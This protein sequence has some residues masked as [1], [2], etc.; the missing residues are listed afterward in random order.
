MNC[1]EGLDAGKKISFDIKH[2]GFQM[3]RLTVESDVCS[4]TFYYQYC[5]PFTITHEGI[6][7][8]VGI[9]PLLTM[10]NVCTKFDYPSLM[11]SLF[12]FFHPTRCSWIN[13]Q[14]TE[15]TL[16]RYTTR[17]WWLNTILA[18]FVSF[19]SCFIHVNLSLTFLFS[20]GLFVPS[21]VSAPQSADRQAHALGHSII[22]P[23]YDRCIEVHTFSWSVHIFLIIVLIVCMVRVYNLRKERL[24]DHR[25]NAY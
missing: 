17:L 10:G 20:L 14:N 25:V 11:G 15:R 24:D 9:K 1:C 4:N 8:L 21:L 6:Y 3:V 13:R 12:S 19:L 16:H 5:F 18:S 23:V 7:E 2:D 22:R